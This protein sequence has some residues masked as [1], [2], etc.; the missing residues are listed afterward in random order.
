MND[1]NL[2]NAGSAG[3]MQRPTPTE[4]AEQARRLAAELEELNSDVRPA[5]E[6]SLLD[7]VREVLSQLRPRIRGGLAKI[8]EFAKWVVG[9]GP[10]PDVEFEDED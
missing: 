3:R 6:R 5:V 7:S 9:I 2:G 10:E 1:R 4:Y 8:N